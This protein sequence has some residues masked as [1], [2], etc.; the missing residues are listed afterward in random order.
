MTESGTTAWHRET[1]PASTA[2]TLRVLRLS[3]LA[4]R[5]Y[6]AGGTGLAL[7]FGH[8]LS[9]D[10]DFFAE[11]HFDEERLLER[12]QVLGG[13]ALAA[14]APYTLHATIA[15]T[16]VSFLGY[17]YPILFPPGNF[18]GVA[19]ADL[20]D[21]ACMKLSAIASRGTRRDFIDLYFC[22]R[23]FGLSELIQLFAKKYAK[24]QTSRTHLLK[25]LVYFADAEKE[26]MPRML[27][28]LDWQEVTQFFNRESLRV[29]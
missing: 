2:E 21:I 23:K 15:E 5:F 6:L 16:K 18:D 3:Q 8:R 27:V 7:Q 28:P 24:I 1:I 10:L 17:A 26:P 12:M 22:A 20:R 29:L 14:I 11:E 13:F 25:S 9:L 4:E 19:V